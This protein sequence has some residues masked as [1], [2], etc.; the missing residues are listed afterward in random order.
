MKIEEKLKQAFDP[1]L[2]VSAEVWKSFA[3]LG[4]I[5]ATKE[6]QIIKGVNSTEKFLS[7][8]LQGSGGVLL[9]NNNNFVCTDLCYEGDFL[10]DYMSFLNQHP[11]QLE[12]IT[13]EPSE[14]FRISRSDFETLTTNSEYGEKIR[15]FAAEALFIQK[16]MQQIDLIT[17]TA[18]QRY[19]CLQQAKQLHRMKRTPLRYIASYLGITPQSLSR[20]S[21]ETSTV[22]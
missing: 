13:F 3:N 4:E 17:K 2:I 14:L 18:A 9:W 21:R 22:L 5:V 7:F 8:I 20:I 16:Q 1:Y 6:G 11:T 12:V 19:I 15:C 10:G